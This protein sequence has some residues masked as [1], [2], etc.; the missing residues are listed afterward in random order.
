MGDAPAWIGQLLGITNRCTEPNWDSYKADAVTISAIDT[1]MAVADSIGV[2]PLNNGGI[3]I[4]F[5]SEAN[6]IE[7]LPDGTVSSV[8]LDVADLNKWT[9]RA[10]ARALASGDDSAPNE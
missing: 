8:Y 10:R 9:D 7:F 3:G 4:Y 2:T 1:A 5:A 6:S